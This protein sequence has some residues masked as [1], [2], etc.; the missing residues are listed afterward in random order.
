MN[1]VEQLNPCGLF[2]FSNTYS[3]L[4]G[5]DSSYHAQIN[6]SV[7]RSIIWAIIVRS[8]HKG[9]LILISSVYI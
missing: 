6:V 3:N 9:E 5:V 7:R 4:W 1:V 2:I 8:I